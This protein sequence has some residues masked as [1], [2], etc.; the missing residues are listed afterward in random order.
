MNKA[1]LSGHL[2]RDPETRVTQDGQ[3]TITRFSIAVDRNR[4][5]ADFLNV[6]TFGKTAE[7]AEKYLRKGQKVIVEGRIRA[8]QYTDRDGQK[9][10]S[11]YII[12]DRLEPCEKKQTDPEKERPEIQNG[13]IGLDDLDSAELPFNF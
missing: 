12:G 2:T 6:T 10:T 8:E 5:E 11:F 7:F 9:K 4:E 1:F 13:F 3:T